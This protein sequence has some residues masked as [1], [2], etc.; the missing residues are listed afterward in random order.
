MNL[1]NLK[2]VLCKETPSWVTKR[3]GFIVDI[4]SD[5]AKTI[6]ATCACETKTLELW[7]PVQF[8]EQSV[9]DFWNNLNRERKKCQLEHL[10]G[11][12]V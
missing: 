1:S 8:T 9:L 5:G 7:A 3:N 11:R 10:F 6:T 12:Q 2:C 4:F